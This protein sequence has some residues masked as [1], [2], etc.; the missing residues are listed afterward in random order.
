M[1]VD[2]KK[3]NTCV[4][5]MAGGLGKR[6]KST[7]PKVLHLVDGI[8]MVVR[9]INQAKKLYPS[10]ILLVVGQ[11]QNIIRDTLQLFNLQEEKDFNFIIQ[12]PALGTGHAIQCCK[13]FL[14][15]NCKASTKVLILSGDTPLVQSELMKEMLICKHAKIMTTIQDNPRGYGRVSVIDGKFD[16]II[17]D[18]DCSPKELCNKLVNCGIYAFQNSLLVEYLSYLTNENAQNEYYLTDLLEII[19]T[20]TNKPIEIYNLSTENQWQLI[21]INTKEQLTTLNIN[22]NK[23]N[24]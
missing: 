7:I 3:S 1:Q 9:V 14:S 13:S 6:M 8:P 4:I 24:I 10:Q 15:L 20:K 5:V 21:G 22:F 18:K 11:Y 23:H 17:E 2:T 19:K 12:S 16:K